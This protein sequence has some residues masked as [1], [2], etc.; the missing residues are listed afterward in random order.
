MIHHSVTLNHS[1]TMLLID[2][3]TE[4]GSVCL[5]HDGHLVSSEWSGA[6]KHVE[7]VLQHIKDLLSE[8]RVNM[9]DIE[10]I[11]F[12]QGPGSFTGL[13][14][15][16]G[17]T[18]GLA[19]A[20]DIP[21]IPVP[22]LLMLAQQMDYPSVTVL[23]DARMGQVY[24]ARYQ[25]QGLLWQETLPAGLYEPQSLPQELVDSSVLVGSGAD[26]YQAQLT[27]VQDKRLP[28]MVSGIQPHARWLMNYALNE[29]QQGR[30]LCADQAIPVYVRDKVA[31]TTLERQQP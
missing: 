1:P 25:R 24:G 28:P 3:A 18:Q 22:T 10:V 12:S 9:A 15:G 14:A 30:T 17:V 31:L 26:I 11:A 21:V 2:T 16:C 23:L 7:S 6:L 29:F 8:G 19:L 27:A 13:R 4:Q 5:T 20:Y